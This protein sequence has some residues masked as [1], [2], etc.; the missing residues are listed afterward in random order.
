[1]ESHAKSAKHPCLD[2]SG[3]KRRAGLQ[4]AQ[5]VCGLIPRP[6]GASAARKIN[7]V[8]YLWHRVVKES[9]ILGNLK[10]VTERFQ[11]QRHQPFS[12]VAALT[13]RQAARRSHGLACVTGGHSER[14][15][16]G[17]RGGTGQPQV[18]GPTKSLRN[19]GAITQGQR[20][21]SR[22]QS[23]RASKSAIY[24]IGNSVNLTNM[25]IDVSIT[26]N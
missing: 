7:R 10:P 21:R 19:C 25:E 2:S 5:P 15:R 3:L 22:R 16:R 8:P 24:Q 23:G 9:Q 14:A 11:Q 26:R 20:R 17:H 6:T 13:R 1:M 18:T 4:Y 12:K